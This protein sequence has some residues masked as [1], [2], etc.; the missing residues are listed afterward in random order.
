V[1]TRGWSALGPIVGGVGVASMAVSGALWAVSGSAYA[2]LRARCEASGCPGDAMAASEANSIR[3]LDAATTATLV[4]GAALTVTGAVL[5]FA[6]R[7]THTVTV[8]GPTVTA[9]SIGA[10]TLRVHGAF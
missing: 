3:M 6:V 10:G 7:P 2:S 4:A 9:L 1:T 8:E 5:L